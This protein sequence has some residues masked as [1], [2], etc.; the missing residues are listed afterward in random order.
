MWDSK[1]SRYAEYATQR[2][3]AEEPALQ[4]CVKHAIKKRDRL[5]KKVFKRKLMNRM[6]SGATPPAGYWE[7]RL[8]H[9]LLM[10]A[11]SHETVYDSHSYL[12]K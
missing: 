3:L 2:R 9:H 12:Q 7:I 11:S 6:N 5:I 8:D 1:M 10:Q 4:L